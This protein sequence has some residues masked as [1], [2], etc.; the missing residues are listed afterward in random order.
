[1]ILGGLLLGVTNWLGLAAYAQ[2]PTVW[3]TPVTISDPD[4]FNWFA[5]IAVDNEGVPHVVWDGGLTLEEKLYHPKQSIPL[6]MYSQLAGSTWTK[7]YDIVATTAEEETNIENVYQPTLVSDQMGKLWL[8]YGGNLRRVPARQAGNSAADWSSPFPVSRGVSFSG[9]IYLDNKAVLHGL[10]DQ[11]APIV[12]DEFGL[13]AGPKKDFADIFYRRS[14]DMGKTWS[15]PVNLSKTIAAES[16]S[17]LEVDT[18]GVLYLTWDEGFDRLT[19][20]GKPEQS[21]LV[22]SHDGGNSWSPKTTFAY[23]EQSNVQLAALGDGQ[24][25]VL[26]VWRTTTRREI[27]YSWSTDDGVSWGI[28]KT[29]PNLFARPWEELTFDGYDLAVDSDR[30]IHLVAVGRQRANRPASH[31]YHLTWDGKEWSVP[32]VVYDGPGWPEYPRL[33]ISQGNKLHLVWFVRDE[34]KLTPYSR[35]QIWYSS[36]VTAASARPLAATPTPTAIPAPVVASVSIT[37]PILLQPLVSEDEVE[38]VRGTGIDFELDA[39][40]GESLNTLLV[41]SLAPLALIILL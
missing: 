20:T 11:E 3:S 18:R 7:P 10:Y 9:N 32:E 6:L 37:A 16:R 35:Y 13:S 1:M 38:A 22:V 24:G 23:P 33:T 29:I 21:I 25:N 36:A 17:N 4:T 26:A 39:D 8:W 34:L 28:P 19:R 31:L 30:D 40:A 14:L 27:F 2:S 15:A 5:D 12:R 41:A